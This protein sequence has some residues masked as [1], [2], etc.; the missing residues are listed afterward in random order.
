MCHKEWVVDKSSKSQQIMQAAERLF[1]SRRFHE[2]TMEDVAKEAGV[3][4]GTIYR[5]F[6]DKDDLFFRIATSGFDELCD[7]LRRKVPGNASFPE[8]L[9]IACRQIGRFFERRRQLSR[10]M[11]SE[12]GRMSWCS[13]QLHQRW[14]EHRKRLVAAVA[15]LV[16]KG[17]SEGEVREDI[18]PVVLANFLMGMLRTRGRDM[19]DVPQAMRQHEVVVELFVRGAGTGR[20]AT[21]DCRGQAMGGSQPQASGS[22]PANAA[23][24]APGA[25]ADKPPVA[26]AT[27]GGRGRGVEA[28]N[29]D[30]HGASEEGITNETGKGL[31]EGKA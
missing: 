3:G 25:L 1:T 24:V 17:V 28:R 31:S 8:Q 29:D 7:L 19:C 11:Q 13:G 9:L 15:D 5:Y 26:P 23:G 27:T 10:M 18:P 6:Q 16:Q 20:T 21:T 4:K 14:M 22:T 12:E 30:N 2:I